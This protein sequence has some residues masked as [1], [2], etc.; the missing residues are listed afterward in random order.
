[1]EAINLKKLKEK[2]FIVAEI[3]NNH[4]GKLERCYDLVDKA[5]SCGVDAENLGNL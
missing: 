3:G 4:E 2:V 1:M 5:K